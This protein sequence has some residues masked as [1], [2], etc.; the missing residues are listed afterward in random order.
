MGGAFMAA[1]NR[2]V[3]TGGA[4][5]IGSH[6]VDELIDHGCEVLVIDDFST[7]SRENLARH[8]KDEVVIEALDI[9]SPFLLADIE[10]FDPDVIFHLAAQTD[11]ATSVKYPLEDAETNILGTLNVLYTAKQIKC[12]V[13]FASSGGA[14]YGNCPT[15]PQSEAARTD[16]QSP[17]AV[18][19]LAAESYVRLADPLNTILRYSNVYGP[20]QS[21]R[22]EGGVVAIFKRAL[23]EGTPPIIYGDGKQ[24]RDFVH[25][26]DVAAATVA[27]WNEPGIFNVG[28][29]HETEIVWLLGFMAKLAGV[30]DIQV[31]EGPARDGDVRYSS[32]NPTRLADTMPWSPLALQ[33]GLRTL[34]VPV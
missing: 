12:R 16:P 30:G 29:G 6:V 1:L 7:G 31:V 2:A 20:R 23:T 5:F 3:V 26:S 14:V 28:T 17:Y 22:A 4:G 13:V 18:S 25:V 32:V 34:G 27:L 10:R 33:D 15:G 11:V 9:E 24:T 19:K 21:D 8:G